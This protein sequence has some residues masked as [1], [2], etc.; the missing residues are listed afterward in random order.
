[1]VRVDT[2]PVA[3][4]VVKFHSEGDWPMS[5]LVDH[6]VRALISSTHDNVAIAVSAPSS[7]PNPATS[8]GIN[9]IFNCRLPRLVA[10]DK[11]REFAPYAPWI[12][13]VT[14][15]DPR[16]LPA[17]A[18]TQPERNGAIVM[19]HEIDSYTESMDCHAG[20]VHSVAR[21]PHFSTKPTQSREY[22]GRC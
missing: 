11:T 20:D 4:Q 15:N 6:F 1:M 7:L 18:L 5:P 12:R 2:C 8:F 3:T 10:A 21:L 17:S 14:L 13:A 22:L 16:C 19:W 9:Q